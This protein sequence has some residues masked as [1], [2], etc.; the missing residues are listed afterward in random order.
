MYVRYHT[1][2]GSPEITKQS[3]P[4]FDEYALSIPRKSGLFAFFYH[5]FHVQKLLKKFFE[6]YPDVSLVHVQVGWK[7]AWDLMLFLKR[8]RIPWVV[9]EHNTDWLPQDRQYPRWKRTLTSWTMRRA[10]A[11]TA[12]SD[13]LAE[14]VS[15]AIARS[16][17]VIPNPVALEFTTADIITP[18][19]AGPVFLHISNFNLRQKQTGKLI[20]VFS[21]YAKENPRAILQLNVPE[22]AFLLYNAA[23]PQYCWENIEWLPP[24]AEKKLLLQRMQNADFVLSY[25]RFETF[26]LVI[27]EALCLGIPVI[28]TPCKGADIHINERMGI[29]CDA[30]REESLLNAMRASSGFS[31]DREY[32]GS[33]ARAVFQSDAVLDAYEALY[34]KI[35]K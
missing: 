4:D 8:K 20:Q 23:N 28:Y 33:R 26:G 6:M 21:E 22:S 2:G 3:Q 10:T 5:Q 27:A 30:D 25:S 15:L 19:N 12:V 11:V 31:A 14:V 32:I 18:E 13:N 1:N 24:V 16:V 9:T 29:A 35:I 34:R 17:E 7:A